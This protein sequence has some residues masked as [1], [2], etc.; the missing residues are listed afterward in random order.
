MVMCT[1][2]NPKSP[3]K[4][5]TKPLSIQLVK[6]APHMGFAAASRESLL[7]QWLRLIGTYKTPPNLYMRKFTI[8]YKSRV[9]WKRKVDYSLPRY[10]TI[11]YSDG[12]ATCNCPG[13][14]QKGECWH[15]RK[16]KQLVT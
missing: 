13:F 12:K 11:R 7:E 2:K 1:N 16:I 14:I 4:G 3:I 15:V 8:H 6:A 9:A 5:L 10:T